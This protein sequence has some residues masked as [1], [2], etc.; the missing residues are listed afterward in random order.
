MSVHVFLI[1]VTISF[2]VHTFVLMIA[3]RGRRRVWHD[4]DD[5]FFEESIFFITCFQ[6]ERIPGE[7]G[8]QAIV[9][10]VWRSS[11]MSSG[12]YFICS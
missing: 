9:S 4:D 2:S 3:Y 8:S 12:Q 1:P 7:R 6:A 5:R 11:L 10:R